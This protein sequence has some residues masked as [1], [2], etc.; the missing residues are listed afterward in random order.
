MLQSVTTACAARCRFRLIRL[1]HGH[2]LMRA[3]HSLAARCTAVQPSR[4]LNVAAASFGLCVRAC[5]QHS[6]ASRAMAH[7]SCASLPAAQCEPLLRHIDRPIPSGPI[8]ISGRCAWHR[9]SAIRGPCRWCALA[10]PL[11]CPPA[12]LQHPAIGLPV[13]I[14]AEWGMQ[15]ATGASAVMPPNQHDTAACQLDNSC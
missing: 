4:R 3:G 6:H 9:A 13:V 10:A 14:A 11:T 5:M 12:N 8:T 15:L 1:V 2:R 7:E